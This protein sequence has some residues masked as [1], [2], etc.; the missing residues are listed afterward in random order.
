MKKT[1]KKSTKGFLNNL[2]TYAIV[3]IAFVFTQM[4]LSKMIPGVTIS[5]SLKGQLIP[6][7]VYIVMAVSLNLTVA[8]S[9]GLHER[10]RVL[11]HHHVWLAAERLPDG[12]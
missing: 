6:I 4:A 9:R 8:W 7:C 5:R 2:I 12:K 3:I 1:M 11:R 10:R